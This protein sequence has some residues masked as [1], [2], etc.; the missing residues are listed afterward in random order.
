[1]M[2]N[3]HIH[4]RKRKLSIRSVRSQLFKNCSAESGSWFIIAKWLDTTT[5]TRIILSCKFPLSQLNIVDNLGCLCW[6]V[7]QCL[8]ASYL[9]HWAT[10]TM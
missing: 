2:M 1:M 7:E 4:Q 10:I 9:N 6:M 5:M 3:A 8:F